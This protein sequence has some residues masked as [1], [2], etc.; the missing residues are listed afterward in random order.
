M[1]KGNQVFFRSGSSPYRLVNTIQC[2]PRD[3]TFHHA[4]EI[5]ESRWKNSTNASEK[6]ECSINK[7]S[8]MYISMIPGYIQKESNSLSKTNEKAK[9]KKRHLKCAPRSASIYVTQ[10]CQKSSLNIFLQPPQW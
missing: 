8:L 9:A 3:T 7:V 6:E 1:A 10:L 4:K 2:L 5:L